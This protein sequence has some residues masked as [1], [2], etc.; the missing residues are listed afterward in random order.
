MSEQRIEAILD[1]WIG[2]AAHDAGEAKARGKLWYQSTPEAD[3]DLRRRFGEDVDMAARGALDDW[4][5]SADGSLALVILLDQF[6]RNLF[7]GTAG[8][9]ANDAMAASIA[10]AAIDAG[11]DRQMSWIGRAFL[12]HPFEHSEQLPRQE[13]SVQLFQALAD[14]APPEWQ[15]QLKGFLEYAVEHR[16]VVR[17]F[18]RFPHR[19]AVLGRESTAIETAYLESG[20][21]RYGQ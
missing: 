11:Q 21:R 6:S 19:N 13:R 16:E 12:Y 2:P 4:R 3:E 8:A 5:R 10:E 18:G 20:A 7:R 17:R 15:E 1:F 14:E 9:F